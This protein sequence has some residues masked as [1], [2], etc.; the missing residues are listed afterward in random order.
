MLITLWGQS[1]LIVL[2][3]YSFEFIVELL[4]EKEMNFISEEGRLLQ[5]TAGI[6]VSSGRK[7]AG[8]SES[9]LDT[10]MTPL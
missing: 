3:T 5:V 8:G 10:V 2:Q 1:P 7:S 6:R 9:D 4:T